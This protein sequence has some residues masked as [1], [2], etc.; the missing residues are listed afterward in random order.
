MFILKEFTF[1]IEDIIN[2][3]LPG[4]YGNNH[5]PSSVTLEKEQLE[6][7]NQMSVFYEKYES[8]LGQVQSIDCYLM[9]RQKIT[10]RIS[11]R[12]ILKCVNIIKLV[13]LVN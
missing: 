3:Q 2:A 4:N 8:I 11:F 1:N 12:F 5:R 6:K 10:K 7:L 9:C 13:D